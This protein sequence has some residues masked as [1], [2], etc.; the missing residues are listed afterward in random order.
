M[1]RLAPVP[2]M[3]RTVTVRVPDPEIVDKTTPETF[4]VLFRVLSREEADAFDKSQREM[5]FE[6]RVPHP[7]LR[8]VVKS[9]D[10]VT[11]ASGNT[12]PFSEDALARALELPWVAQALMAEYSRGLAGEPRL[13]N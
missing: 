7:L 9:W 3:R 12:I 2:T 8:H 10:G 11:D 6:E 1:F 5:T 4:T 13:G